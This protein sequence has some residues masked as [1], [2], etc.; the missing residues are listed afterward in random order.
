MDMHKMSFASDSFDVVYC[1][2]S[3][4][5]AF[6]PVKAISELTRTVRDGGVIVVEVPVN[7]DKVHADWVAD[8]VDFGSSEDLE[9][10]FMPYVK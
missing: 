9:M 2:H 8:L 5:H 10:L 6:D 1:S 3:L 4:E 7:D